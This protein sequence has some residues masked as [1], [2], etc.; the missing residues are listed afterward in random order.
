MLHSGCMA[1][2]TKARTAEL[3]ALVEEY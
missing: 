1:R 3:Q 2:L